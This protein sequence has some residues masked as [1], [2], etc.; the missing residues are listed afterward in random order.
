[1]KAPKEYKDWVKRLVK[2]FGKKNGV[3]YSGLLDFPV[4]ERKLA[5]NKARRIAKANKKG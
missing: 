3:I 5:N 2:R 1:M 4:M